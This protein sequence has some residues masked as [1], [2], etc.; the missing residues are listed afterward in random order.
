VRTALALPLLALALGAPAR[1]DELAA[2]AARAYTLVPRAPAALAVGAPADV[3]VVIRCEPGVHVQ[4]QAPLRA[5][6]S[7]SPGLTLG[8]ARL[9]W[10]DVRQTGDAQELEVPVSIRATAPGPAEVRLRLD[11]FVCSKE[12]CVRQERELTVPV[13]AGDAAAG[14]KATSAA[15]R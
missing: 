8:K 7:V 1:G 14:S 12:W 11:F 5:T 13:V 15:G 10:S 3:V 4:R 2:R 9:G 6:A